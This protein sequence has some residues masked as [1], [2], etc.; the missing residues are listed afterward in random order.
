MRTD[1]RPR[2][3]LAQFLG[4]KSRVNADHAVMHGQWMPPGREPRRRKK[5]TRQRMPVQI[6]RDYRLPRRF[7]E[8]IQNA[9]HAVVIEMMQK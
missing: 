8:M 3:E 7:F 4:R 1:A 6:Y 5:S 2:R 9:P